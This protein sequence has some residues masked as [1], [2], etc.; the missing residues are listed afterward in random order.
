MAI[1]YNTMIQSQ[2]VLRELMDYRYLLLRDLLY[3]KQRFSFCFSALGKTLSGQVCED[4]T[5]IHVQDTETYTFNSHVQFQSDQAEIDTTTTAL[6]IREHEDTKASTSTLN[7]VEV[8][9]EQAE[10]G[11]TT[12]LPISL[13]TREH[14]DTKASTLNEVQVQAEIGTPTIA[15][16]Q[17]GHAATSKDKVQVQDKIG[18]IIRRH[19]RMRTGKASS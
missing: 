6:P 2:H 12:S 8:Q 14:E 9:A 11:T 10:I 16:P 17:H 3:S 13:P 18:A 4:R 5:P 1:H 15:L 7:Q 19:L